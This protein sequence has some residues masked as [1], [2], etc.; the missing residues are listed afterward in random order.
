MSKDSRQITNA[1][2][3]KEVEKEKPRN[4]FFNGPTW[5]GKC[6]TRIGPSTGLKTRK[7]KKNPDSHFVSHEML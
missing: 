2:Q 1:T 5:L 6:A 3:A 4:N 7:G